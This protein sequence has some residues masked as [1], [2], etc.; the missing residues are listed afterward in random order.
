MEPLPEDDRPKSV[1]EDHL[2]IDYKEK[3]PE[4]HPWM[5]EHRGV[6]NPIVIVQGGIFTM[7]CLVILPRDYSHHVAGLLEFLRK[8]AHHQVAHEPNISFQWDVDA[9]TAI[10]R[11]GHWGFTNVASCDHGYQFHEHMWTLTLPKSD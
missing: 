5:Q 1:A 9:A 11:I 2:P 8:V 6:A 7:H 10:S 4:I 3:H